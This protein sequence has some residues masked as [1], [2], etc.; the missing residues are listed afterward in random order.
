[1]A[2]YQKVHDPDQT[3]RRF[4]LV[5]PR[6]Q[7]PGFLEFVDNLPM[8]WESAV[9]RGILYQF[10]ESHRQIGDLDDAVRSAAE[11][12]RADPRKGITYALP[13]TPSRAEETSVSQD[14]VRHSSAPPVPT[15]TA[16]S[17]PGPPPA[18]APSSMSHQPAAV[19]APSPEGET[20]RKVDEEAVA[21]AREQLHNL[22]P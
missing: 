22:F 7:C 18:Q 20:V 5:V 1:M 15:T 6:D 19:A 2:R 8:R 14:A 17:E 4:N 10:F 16:T 12:G 3:E 13:D 21:G 9:L 11:R